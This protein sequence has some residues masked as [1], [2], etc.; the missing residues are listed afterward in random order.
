MRTIDADV[1]TLEPQTVQHADEMFAVLRDPAIYEYENQPPASVEWLRARFEKLESRR[2]ADGTEQWLNWV[3]RLAGA[4][5]I[6]YVQATVRADGSAAIAYELSSAHWGR[7]LARRATE[8]MLGE[9]VERYRVTKF[10][11][12][13]KRENSR[14][15]RLLTRLGFAPAD[16]RRSAMGEIEPGEILMVREV[17][18]PQAA[19]AP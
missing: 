3:V 8:A 5:L 19:H 11:A 18:P 17:V 10:S 6:G 12:V 13:A 14:S 9:L 15:I 2:S 4:G 1:V 16:S 7:G